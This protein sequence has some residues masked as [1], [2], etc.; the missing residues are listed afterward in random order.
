MDDRAEPAA[1]SAD[2]VAKA[3]AADKVA[4]ADK[5]AVASADLPPRQSLLHWTPMVTARFRRKKLRTQWQPSRS[6]TR[7][8]T[9]SC[10]PKKHVPLAPNSAVADPVVLVVLE[11]LRA[12][13]E[14]AVKWS[15]A[16]WNW[17]RTKTARSPKTKWVKIDAPRSSW[18]ELTPTAM[19]LSPKPKSRSWLSS[20]KAAVAVGAALADAAAL[21]E[22]APEALA[23]PEALVDDVLNARLQ[24]KSKQ[25]LLD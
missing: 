22:G 3:V 19:A 21:A 1:N 8:V 25:P 15:L 17:I 23:V 10:P 13:H 12:V 11:A 4:A 5:A 7:T 24:T 14:A 16:S 20:S 9:A 2:A 6:S 18:A